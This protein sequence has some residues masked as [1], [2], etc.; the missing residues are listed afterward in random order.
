MTP[1][2]KF[3]LDEATVRK[4]RHRAARHGRSM[5]AEICHILGDVAKDEGQVR[6]GIE[7]A[8]L[9]RRSGP[10]RLIRYV[11]GSKIKPGKIR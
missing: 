3:D 4:L 2:I 6:T 1:I 8:A 5:N 10:R 9:S 11:R 7:S